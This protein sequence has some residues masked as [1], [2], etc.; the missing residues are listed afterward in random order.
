MK[1]LPL[2]LANLGRHKKRTVLTI[3]SVALALFLFASL[4][5]VITT[6]SAASRFGSARRL[7]AMNATGMTLDLPL[8]YANRLEAMPGVERVTWS[9]WFGGRYGDGKRF[10]AAFAVDPRSY[11][12][13]Y[14]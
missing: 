10:F 3:A 8:A 4:K 14:P 12:D 7:V 6:M 5:T 9:N 11:L 1:Y 13:L 2:V